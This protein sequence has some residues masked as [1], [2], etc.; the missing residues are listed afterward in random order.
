MQAHAEMPGFMSEL[1]LELELGLGLGEIE[2]F[3]SQ[4]GC[5]GMVK[6]RR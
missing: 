3:V 5:G 6:K 1:E 2:Q 4:I